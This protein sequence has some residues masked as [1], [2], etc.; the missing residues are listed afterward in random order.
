TLENTMRGRVILEEGFTKLGGLNL[1]KEQLLAID[2]ITIT[3]CGTSW[4]SAL[5][6]E[7]MIEELCRIPVAVEYASEYRYRNPI[8]TP[9]AR[10]S[11]QSVL[12]LPHHVQS[13]RARAEEI[14][15]LPEQFESAHNLLYLGRGYNCPTAL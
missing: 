5:I 15:A 9:S 8:V 11:A 12:A 3:A 2:N 4:H 1:S 7:M 14:E 10:A 6:G 13:I